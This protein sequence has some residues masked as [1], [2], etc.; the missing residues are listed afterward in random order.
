[1]ASEKILIVDDDEDVL[2]IVQTIL[3]NSG[4]SV[5]LA[6]NGREGVEKAIESSPDLILLDVMMPELSG[7]EVCTTL[8][9]APETRQIPI[10]MLTVKSEIRD[11]I[12][13][14][15]VGADDYI[16]KPFTRKKLLSTVRRL[17]DEKPGS[18]PAYLT[19]ENEEM[20]FKNLLF[21]AVTELPT[22]PV[23]ID[24]L[25]D[26]L[27][28]NRDMGVLYIDVEQY[29]HIEETYGWEVFDGLLQH[30]ART[31]RRMIGTVFATE[32]FIAVNRTGGSD[33]YVF[34]TLEGGE[35]AMTRLQRKARQVEE[36][37]RGSLDEAFGNR[38]H[39]RIGVFVGHAL[40]RPSP[41]MRVERLVY[42]ALGQ[43]IS[44][45]TTKEEERQAALRETFK[46]ILRRHRIRTVYQ[47]IFHLEAMEAFGH[48][49][50][51]RGPVETAFESPELL[52]QFARENEATW[53]LEQLC[54]SSS[55]SRYGLD[56]QSHLFIN[57]EAE[58][59]TA[60]SQG[61]AEAVPP[62][63]SLKCPVVLEVTER[64]AIR[65]VPVFRAALKQLRDRGF[66]IAIDD[67]GSGYASLQAIAELRPDFIKVAN[68]LITGLRS[69]S[70]KR[71]VVEMLVNLSRR[72]DAVCVA[73][74]IETPEDLEECRRLGIPYGQGFYLG[75]PGERPA[76]AP[77][78]EFTGRIRTRR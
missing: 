15:Q 66:R 8:K 50:L 56:G 28:D 22:V 77:A 48:E 60:L 37:L 58:T 1:M 74:G 69:D 59:I 16:T 61:G 67:A 33:F 23:I 62:L 17:L 19:A 3:D 11:L 70:I 54:L 7:W 75:V 30:T 32:D 18:P 63:F 9:S 10:A 52:F 2:L 6:R 5:V 47:P 55:A 46:E 65:D 21:D 49:A 39:K 12:T 20:R 44:V 43:A 27:L 38:I 64:S 42:R 14:M 34:A 41:Q 4:Y 29:S 72:I 24:A 71:D 57:V 35:E 36:S 40:L 68:T 73:E 76:S 53:E 31:L 78:R 25:R 51:T 13:G 45:A 26:R